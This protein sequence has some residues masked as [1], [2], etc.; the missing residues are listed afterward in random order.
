MLLRY[1]VVFPFGV[2]FL[3]IIVLSVHQEI[4]ID[5]R[6]DSTTNNELTNLLIVCCNYNCIFCI[7]YRIIILIIE[8]KYDN[9]EKNLCWQRCMNVDIFLISFFSYLPLSESV[10][11]VME[12]LIIFIFFSISNFW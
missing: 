9:R 1:F 3:I 6:R 10:V 4:I 5:D 2:W 11:S 8:A 12:K 7:N